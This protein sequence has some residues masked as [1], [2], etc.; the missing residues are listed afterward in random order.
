MATGRPITAP[1]GHLLMNKIV[2]FW[3]MVLLVPA[4]GAGAQE[5]ATPKSNLEALEEL[6]S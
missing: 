6:K 5:A 1:A 4:W 2:L 3:L